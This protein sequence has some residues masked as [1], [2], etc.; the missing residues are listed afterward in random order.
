MRARRALLYVPGD[1]RHKTEKA[2]NL[3]ADC[4]CLD[5]EDGVAIN[6]KDAARREVVQSLASLDFKGSE[7]LVRLNSLSSGFCPR[8]LD[9]I[10]P[11][12]PDGVYL[13]KVNSAGEIQW[14]NE[15]ISDFEVRERLTPGAI[16]LMA[17]IE[18]A[19]AILNLVDI[20]KASTRLS[21]LVFGA[22]D[23]IADIGGVRTP[24]GEA[25]FYAR[26][27]VVICAAAY[28]LQAIDMVCTDYKDEARLLEEC[29]SG[30]ELGFS[31]KQII[32][33]AQVEPVQRVFTPD[34]LALEQATRIVKAYQENLV[35]G[36]GAFALDGKMVDLPVVKAAE[37]L[38]ARAAAFTKEL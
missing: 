10:L 22:E 36:K 33:P 17:G 20:C 16:S 26:S 9:A 32:H 18:S 13:P 34:P 1:D 6:H 37:R 29:R 4:I 35:T 7:R 14:I 31:G 23:Y 30:V 2:T 5:L 19:L 15:Q 27:V 12:R 28:D 38:M 21:G 8:D 24:D 11:A 3:N 25:F